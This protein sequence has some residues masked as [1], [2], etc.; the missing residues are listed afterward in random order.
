M[1][2]PGEQDLVLNTIPPAF[3][4]RG[5]FFFQCT[6]PLDAKQ[7][8]AHIRRT[9]RMLASPWTVTTLGG[10]RLGAV[11]RKHYEEAMLM[12]FSEQRF[13]MMPSYAR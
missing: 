8:A 7:R 9:R 1:K 2:G 11:R 10:R 4:N 13:D 5:P 6:H 12:C 3:L